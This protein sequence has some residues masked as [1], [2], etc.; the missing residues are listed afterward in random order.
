MCYIFLQLYFSFGLQ[1][2]THCIHI[3]SYGSPSQYSGHYYSPCVCHNHHDHNLHGCHLNIHLMFA[4]TR[5]LFRPIQGGIFRG[6]QFR[7]NISNINTIIE[8]FSIFI[9]ESVCKISMTSS[10]TSSASSTFY[11]YATMVSSTASTTTLATFD[12]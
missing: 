12:T 2:C 4:C 10:P 1:V 11:S 8:L 5:S 3:Y 6:R 9:D 7:F